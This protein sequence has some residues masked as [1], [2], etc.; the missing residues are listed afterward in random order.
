M[1]LILQRLNAPGKGDV[2]GRVVG[3]RWVGAW[4]STL[5]ET[6]GRRDGVK[7]SGRGD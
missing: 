2:R 4:R 6:K 7:N 5:S 1:H 3:K